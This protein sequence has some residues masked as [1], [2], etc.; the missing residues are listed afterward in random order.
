MDFLP[1][2][3]GLHKVNMKKQWNFKEVIKVILITLCTLIVIGFVYQRISNFLAKET[4]KPKVDYT[5]VND[6]R[7][8]YIYEGKGEYTIIFDGNLGA[9]IN[10]WKGITDKLNS[11]YNEDVKTFV[12][13]RRGYGYSDGGKGRTPLEQAEDLKI[14]LRKANAQPPYI[15]VGE[16]YGSLILT[17]FA[18]LYPETV[19]GVVLVNPILENEVASKSYKK[20]FRFSKLRR[21]IE[22]VG[23]YIGLTS[24][25]DK[26][27]LDAKL[28]EFENYLNDEML[29]EFKT[30]RTKSEYTGAVYSELSNLTNG[31]SESQTDGLLK[32]KPYYLIAKE[33]QESLARLGDGDLTK[34]YKTN[35]KSDFISISNEDYIIEGIRYVIK[36][37]KKNE[38]SQS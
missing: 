21:G 20:E 9:N 23:S 2:S 28:D 10:Q 5:R 31:N 32:G 3:N 27:N 25:L 12:Y 37:A 19:D 13:N 1:Y 34:I 8:D 38:R 29:E 18:K 35:S 15:L 24:F 6:M 16:E 14:L 11:E 36:E 33:G 17:N 7:L 30:H 26:F 22:H 4:L